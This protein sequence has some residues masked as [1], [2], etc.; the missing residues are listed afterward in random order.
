MLEF[1]EAPWLHL[2]SSL[3]QLE[4]KLL[5][6]C[7]GKRPLLCFVEINVKMMIIFL[8]KSDSSVS[9]TRVTLKGKSGYTRPFPWQQS[10]AN[11]LDKVLMS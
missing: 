11:G 8:C 6:G 2:T 9:W 4:V 10:H 1:L 5:V 7:G 3:L